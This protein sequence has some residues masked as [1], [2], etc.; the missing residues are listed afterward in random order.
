MMPCAQTN[1]Q[2]ERKFRYCPIHNTTY[3]GYV[4]NDARMPRKRPACHGTCSTVPGKL[5]RH[6]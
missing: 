4:V 3:H 1:A 6:V 2:S 5:L